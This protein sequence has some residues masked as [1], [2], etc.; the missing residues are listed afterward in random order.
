MFIRTKKRG[1]IEVGGDEE[2]S[3][4][5]SKAFGPILDEMYD[6]TVAETTLKMWPDE[7]LTICMSIGGDNAGEHDL[8]TVKLQELINDAIS[9]ANKQEKESIKKKLKEIANSF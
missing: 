1:E 5:L 9:Y 4:A 6:L 2:L 8:K 7:D 3:E